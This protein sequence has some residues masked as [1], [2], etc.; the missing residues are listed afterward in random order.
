[1]NGAIPVVFTCCVGDEIQQV[2]YFFLGTRECVA[3]K[4]QQGQNK[5]I[6]RIYHRRLI[7]RQYNTRSTPYYSE[8]PDTIRVYCC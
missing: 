7:Y 6:G 2:V 1:M 5:N 4:Q 3:S 8:H